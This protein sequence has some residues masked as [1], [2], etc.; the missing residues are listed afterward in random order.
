M[1]RRRSQ[2][3]TLIELLVV[4]AIIAILAAILFPVFAQAK[5]AAKKASDISNLKQLM[6]AG[7]IYA[8]DADDYL[9]GTRQYEPYVFAARILPYTKNRQIFKNPASSN[10]QGT[11]QKKQQDNGFGEY[12]TAPDNACVGLGV[13]AVGGGKKYYNDI[14]PPL[15]YAVNE[16]IFGYQKGCAGDPNGYIHFGPN[17]SSGNAGGAGGENGPGIINVGGGSV[18]FTN[19]SKVVLW[20]DFPIHGRHWPGNQPGLGGFW[21]SNFKGYFAEGS[22]VGHMDGH[23][24]HYKNSKLMA[25]TDDGTDPANAWS[26]AANAGQ[27]YRWWGTNFA[28]QANQ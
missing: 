19:I 9:P 23:A 17:A 2:G 6:T 22:N 21:G 16:S 14:Y 13:S 8:N 1:T 18:N 27:D 4:I 15:D 11:T 12:M 25:N 24:A 7:L 26:G 28:N 5:T 10:P 3:F 20:I